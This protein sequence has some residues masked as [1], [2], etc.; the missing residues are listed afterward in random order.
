M[1]AL[2]TSSVLGTSVK[3]DFLSLGAV[4]TD[5]L[6]NPTCL[7]DH[8]HQFY[9]AYTSLRPEVGYE[10]MRNATNNSGNVEENKSLYWHPA[11][12]KHDRVTGTYTMADIWF[13]SAYY[14][15]ETNATRA[16]PNGFNM[17]ARA[18]HPKSRANW[19][20]EAPHACERDDCSSSSTWFPRHA[21][22]VLEASFIFPTCWDG[23]NVRSANQE[24][25]VSYDLS[26]GGQFDG[27]CP[28]THPVKLPEIHLYFRIRDYEGGE[29]LF[30]DGSSTF[31]A[32]YFSGWDEAFLQ[33][34]LD[35]CINYSDAASP[36]AFCD[37]YLTYRDA[38]K[39]QKQDDAIRATLETLQPPL[40]NTRATVSP[41]AVTG[42]S[43]LPQ[44]SCTGTLL[45]LG[46]GSTTPTLSP[47][48]SPPPA[49]SGGSSPS[50]PPS[51]GSDDDNPCFPSSGRVTFANGTRARLDA[52][53]EGDMIVAASLSGE[54]VTDTVSFLSIA[55]RD[56]LAPFVT[57][58]TSA[59]ATLTL[60]PHHHLPVGEACCASLTRADGVRVGD[61]LWALPA[62][63]APT[64]APATAHT[65]AHIGRSQAAGLH[66]P[67]LTH[68]HLPV[69]D[70]IV[71]APDGPA[72]MRL[73]AALS[74]YLVPLT[75]ATGMADLLRRAFFA[76]GRTY[77]DGFEAHA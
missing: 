63:G 57:L 49:A 66:S 74:P 28:S 42:V 72:A 27:D 75:K 34:V 61:T 47:S 59:N 51:L 3:M 64:D 54:R 44:G 5:A 55:H 58:T 62:V 70:D 1:L 60:T 43:A 23:V 2:F 69:V 26:E 4:R 36:D 25:H 31:H 52:L 12:Y 40:I 53:S 20:C 21:C 7:S 50:P 41:E 16:F 39:Y 45:P 37:N 77:V 14:V 22:A 65:V 11:I 71:T 76:P 24:D 17:I 32:D 48:P 67:V 19:T 29:Y 38:P 6:L 35:E 8:V 18:S 15:W 46:S 68:G 10:E 30:S 33:R 56:V 13:F 9:G 73:A